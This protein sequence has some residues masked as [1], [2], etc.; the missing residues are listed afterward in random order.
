MALAEPPIQ[1]TSADAII[2]YVPAVAG[3]VIVVPVEVN[4]V[5]L[6]LNVP[7][8]PVFLDDIALSLV[9]ELPVTDDA[10]SVAA[11]LNMDHTGEAGVPEL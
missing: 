5:L 4:E 10:A 11:L 2:K 3:K 8:K 9:T 6:V 7:A 1:A